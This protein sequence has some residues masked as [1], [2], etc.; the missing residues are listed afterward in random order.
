MFSFSHLLPLYLEIER[1]EVG[2]K[3]EKWIFV[4]KNERLNV[5]SI[6]KDEIILRDT[7]KYIR[8]VM[9]RNNYL[10]F[11]LSLFMLLSG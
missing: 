7:F 1:V 11:R 5:D 9:P 10:Q 3:E 4:R 8:N 2:E 6:H